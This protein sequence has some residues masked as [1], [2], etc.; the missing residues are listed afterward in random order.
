VKTEL[1]LAGGVRYEKAKELFLS[2]CPALDLYSQAVTKE[3]AEAALRSAVS[4]FIA[5]CRYQGRLEA[6]LQD[7][8][9]FRYG[10]TFHVPP[11]AERAY[12][13]TLKK[14][15]DHIFTVSIPLDLES[16]VLRTASAP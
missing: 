12:T 8:E 6:V 9:V 14:H 15:Y 10:S 1:A 7:A 2:Y 3:R 4:L 16:D 5:A 13:Q 11:D